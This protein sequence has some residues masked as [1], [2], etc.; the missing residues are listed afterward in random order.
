MTNRIFKILSQYRLSRYFRIGFLLWDII[1]LNLAIITPQL[2]QF[3][4]MHRLESMQIQTIALL[5]NMI[6][7]FLLFYKSYEQNIRVE[8]IET[9]LKRTFKM[10]FIHMAMIAMFILALKYDEISRLRMLYFYICFF[11]YLTFF[12]IFFMTILKYS[13]SKG[14]NFKNVVI[15]GA[16]ATGKNMQKILMRNLTYGYHVLGFF[17]DHAQPN[18]NSSVNLLGNLDAIQDYLIKEQVDEMYVALR[19][20]NI[21]AI[22]GLI[23]LCERYMVRLK[24]IPAYL[25]YTNS[26]KVDISFYETIPVFTIRKEPLQ[27]NFNRVIKKIFDLCFSLFVI[28]SIFPW[29]FPIIMILIKIDSPGPIFFRQKRSGQDNRNFS[30][31][32]FRTM[33]VNSNS[34]TAQATAGD[35]RVT[36]IGAF[37]RKSSMDEL[38]QFFNVLWGDMSV[39]GPR[40]HMLRHTE[41]YSEL[42][43]NFL[44][45]HYAKPGITGWAQVNGYRGET[46]ELVDMEKRVKYDIWYV[47]N[48]RFLLDLKIVFFTVFNVVKGEKNAY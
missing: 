36:K 13:R 9:I 42:I 21:A 25:Q 6:W 23:E 37:L 5:C 1:L 11:V 35:A 24:F 41:Q 22:N 14:Y 47:E 39:V 38:P 27:S 12:R 44:V 18:P 17:D 19:K 2:I 30:C 28:L 10:L 40:P 4:E 48:W 29:L 8:L 32:K 33:R 26:R 7:I 34:D 45:R 31:L 15:V 16:N 20:D 43:N 3:G 46:K